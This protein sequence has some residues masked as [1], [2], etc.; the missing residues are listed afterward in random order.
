MN[1]LKP[2]ELRNTLRISKSTEN[3]LFRSGIPSLGKGRL[4]RYDKEAAIEWFRTHAHQTTSKKLLDPGDYRCGQCGYE[5]SICPSHLVRVRDA[6][7]GKGR[8]GSLHPMP[9]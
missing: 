6:A 8:F 4:R 1:F 9:M 7:Q 3:R 2:A 5:A